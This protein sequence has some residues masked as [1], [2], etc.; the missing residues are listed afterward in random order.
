MNQKKQCFTQT[1]IYIACDS[2]ISMLFLVDFTYKYWK[3]EKNIFVEKLKN[4]KY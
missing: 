3:H 2:Q 1:K 4:F